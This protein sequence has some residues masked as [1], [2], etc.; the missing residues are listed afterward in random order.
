MMSGYLMVGGIVPCG[1]VWGSY[2]G[3]E[4]EWDVF[5]L[6]APSRLLY[7]FYSTFTEEGTPPVSD[8]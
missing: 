5:L 6:Q 3:I 1:V 7:F 2:R 4:S 8:L